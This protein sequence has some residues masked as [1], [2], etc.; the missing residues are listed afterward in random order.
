MTLARPLAA[1]LLAASF[2]AALAAGL[3]AHAAPG[4][5][6]AD[7]A[8]PPA[9]FDPH[10]GPDGGPHGAPYGGPGA[11]GG[12]GWDGPGPGMPFGHLHGLALSEAQQDKL[13]AILHAQAPQRR[14]Q[15]KAVR[16]A[17][18]G[19]RELG[20]AERFDEARA[21]ALSRDLGQAV[22]AEALL[23]A[24]TEAQVL[25]VLTPEQRAALR[26]RRERG[27]RGDQSAARRP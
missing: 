20:R 16:K 27:P 21:A 19:L 6:P 14:D 17:A 4:A 24:R 23:R 10:G 13:F 3:P 22:A 18:D 9:G 2:A 12:P 25:A 7:A 8:P 11:F 26:Q 15:Q 5:T 1:A